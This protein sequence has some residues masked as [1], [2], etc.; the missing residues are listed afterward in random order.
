M[1][2]PAVSVDESIPV[3]SGI[4][5]KLLQDTPVLIAPI[6]GDI[7]KL[8]NAYFLE[9]RELKWTDTGL[10]AG[11]ARGSIKVLDSGNMEIRAKSQLAATIRETDFIVQHAQDAVSLA[12]AGFKT[13][14]GA[15]FAKSVRVGGDVYLTAGKLDISLPSNLG[16]NDQ[17]IKITLAAPQVNAVPLIL[18]EMGAVANVAMS[19]AR[20]NVGGAVNPLVA[21]YDVELGNDSQARGYRVTDASKWGS[22]GFEYNSLGN[23]TP[24]FK[25]AGT[26]FKANI[27]NLTTHEARLLDF[28]ILSSSPGTNRSLETG[29]YI[30]E[31]RTNPGI[32]NIND[33]FDMLLFKRTSRAVNAGKSLTSA[34]AAVVFENEVDVQAG[35]VTDSVNVVKIR[36][37]SGSTGDPFMIEQN[38]T[39]AG[40]ISGVFKKY[41]SL[42]GLLIYKSDGTTP[43]GNVSGSAGDV[44]YNGPS[45]QIFY[46]T[47]TTNWTG[48]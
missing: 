9:F 21:A 32:S 19:G 15:S 2:G 24:N 18:I 29:K 20:I 7:S 48:A 31:R 14:G 47:G 42:D 37:A 25:Q 28:F 26:A 41:N 16:L 39:I 17:A 33:N 27:N 11:V 4:D 46:C 12:V 13:A 23:P 43:Q 34:G 3:F 30:S 22:V 36:Q 44:C 38:A 6:T 1:I 5:G 45:G 8:G 35:G 10:P 40:L